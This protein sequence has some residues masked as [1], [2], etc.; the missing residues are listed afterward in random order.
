MLG[1]LRDN[2]RAREIMDDREIIKEFL[3]TIASVATTL[4]THAEV[5]AIT[6][7]G[8]PHAIKGGLFPS[9]LDAHA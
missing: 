2:Q 1:Y 4:A 5:R 8:R 3:T 7:L 6:R 9:P